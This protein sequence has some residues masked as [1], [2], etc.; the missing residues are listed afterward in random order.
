M[1]GIGI[2]N[3]INFRNLTPFFTHLI[4]VEL[5][6]TDNSGAI[7]L[8]EVY[9]DGALLGTT[10]SPSYSVSGLASNT[11]YNM[12]VRAR[13]AAGNWSAL[14]SPAYP[15]TTALD[16]NGDVDGDGM[17]NGWEQAHF[18]SATAGDPNG[19]PD[20]DGFTNVAEFNL[21]RKTGSGLGDWDW[22][23]MEVR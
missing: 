20:G 8:Y 19:D 5:V 14:N 18:G 7:S 1:F 2:L 17:S 23:G 13:D 12:T 11:S 22:R 6:S 21:K 15:V 3:N 9:K 10:A 4:H 16:P